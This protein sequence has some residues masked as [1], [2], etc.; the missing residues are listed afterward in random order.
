MAKNGL[1]ERTHDIVENVK[2]LGHA[3]R[4]SAAQG[5]ET[6]QRQG[7]RAAS[8][9]VDRAVDA[10]ERAAAMVGERPLTAVLL[11]LGVA[12]VVGFCMRRPS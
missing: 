9:A 12:L 6:V 1:S 10:E 11:A 2:E 4:E 3:A 7:R 5:I 8:S